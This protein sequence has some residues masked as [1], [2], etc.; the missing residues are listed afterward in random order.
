MHVTAFGVYA[1]A[2][3]VHVTAPVSMFVFDHHVAAFGVYVAAFNM[4]VTAPVYMF[5]FD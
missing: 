3:I 5:V 4:H 2:I 1:A